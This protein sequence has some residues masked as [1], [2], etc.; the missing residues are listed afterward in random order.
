MTIAFE[1][2]FSAWL[3][4]TKASA[5]PHSPNAWWPL[6]NHNAVTKPAARILIRFIF[7]LA[8]LART[9]AC[10]AANKAQI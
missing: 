8:T 10:N 6:A 9:P 2:S 1:G 4:G 3:F 5:K 7:Y